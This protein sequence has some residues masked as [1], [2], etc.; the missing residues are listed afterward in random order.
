LTAQEVKILE[1]LT[2]EGGGVTHSK[3]STV[4]WRLTGAV[5]ASR[6]LA[7][8]GK[9]YLQDE[10][11]QL[12]AELVD[13]QP[14]ELILD[15]CAAPGSKGTLMARL[16]GD[17][18]R[19]SAT[20]VHPGRVEMIR[21]TASK[22]EFK[23]I[24]PI[25]A[26]VRRPPFKIDLFDRILVDAP[27]SGTGTLRRNPEIRWR[28][29]SADIDQLGELQLEILSALAPTLKPGGRMVYSTCSVERTENEEVIDS[30]LRKCR[31]FRVIEPRA[32]AE[33]V[34]SRGFVRSWPHK[35]GADGFFAAVLQRE[36]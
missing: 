26:D 28:L 36:S 16:A 35:D 11:S 6:E 18:A 17:A 33:L 8:S 21:N 5:Q 27:C 20:D 24:E 1:E 4:G 12:V 25:V 9:I 23:G 3:I 13:P 34:T 10:A 19:I 22:Q 29:K 2:A 7:S 30:F 15:A 14:G 31:G 32:P